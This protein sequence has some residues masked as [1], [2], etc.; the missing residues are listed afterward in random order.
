MRVQVSFTRTTFAEIRAAAKQTNLPVASYLREVVE[1]DLATRRMTFP[2]LPKAT[3][4]GN[5]PIRR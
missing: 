4:N 2:P 1:A 5:A 3:S